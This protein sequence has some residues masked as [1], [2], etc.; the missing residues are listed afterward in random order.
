MIYRRFGFLQSRLLLNKQAELHELEKKLEKMDRI[1]AKKDQRWP[2]T[3]DLPV[4]VREPRAQLLSQIEE[5][6]ASY[7]ESR[8]ASGQ[9]D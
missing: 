6:F 1:E 4:E 5:K 9:I 8:F 7:S 2:R 3:R